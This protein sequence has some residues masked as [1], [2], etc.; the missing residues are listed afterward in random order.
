MICLPP[1]VALDSPPLRLTQ[2]STLSPT[3]PG[4]RC[5]LPTKLCPL[6]TA[7]SPTMRG[8]P[9]PPPLALSPRGA[10]VRKRRS[11]PVSPGRGASRASLDTTVRPEATLTALD[12]ALQCHIGG[13]RS[14]GPI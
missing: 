5:F 13:S 14:C 9:A 1:S 10:G 2:F 12:S 11:G 4:R 3:H 6:P 8:M 7:G